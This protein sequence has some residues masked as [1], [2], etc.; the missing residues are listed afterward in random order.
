MRLPEK[1]AE[2]SADL[3]QK[4]GPRAPRILMMKSL[5]LISFSLFP[6]VATSAVGQ[7]FSGVQHFSRNAVGQMGDLHV[8]C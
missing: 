1:K 4:E 2:G 3:V 8:G 5:G 7:G 6:R